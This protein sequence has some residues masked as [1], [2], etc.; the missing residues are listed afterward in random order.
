MDTRPD[1]SEFEILRQLRATPDIFRQLEARGGA[2]LHVQAELRRQFP[3]ALVRAALT[4]R[5][6]RERAAGKF[7]WAEAMWFDRV[8]L[9]QAT[10]EP[11]ARYKAERFEGHVWDYCCGIGSDTA[12]LAD[13]CAVTAVDVDPAA[14]LR[15]KWNA[16]VY[17]VAD[18]VTVLC[19]DVTML[20]DRHGLLHIDPDRRPGR[21]GRV[22]RVEDSIPGLDFL[23][24]MTHEFAGG[25]IKLSP[26]GNFMGKFPDAEIE[27]I[28]LSG[29]CKEATI[30]FGE[31]AGEAAFRATVLPSGDSLAGNPLEAYIPVGELGGYLYDP[32]PAIVRSGLIDVLADQIGLKR[33]DAAEEYLTAD[34]F[35]DSPFVRGFRVLAEL[36]NNDREIRRFFRTHEFGQVEIKCRRIP[37]HVEA[38]RRKLPLKGARPGVIV[39]A[40][41]LG[42]ARAVVCERIG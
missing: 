20:S 40:R 5:D 39:F 19:A 15:T 42:R 22:V 1:E 7:T 10:A 24:Q 16:E 30:W 38:V 36:P 26:A 11:V 2:E 18:H 17:G 29:E 9:E 31:L 23:T 8:G 32:D 6:L 27:L 41:I 3:D 34:V 35:V 25:A 21:G 4:L 37:I 28:S 13:H 14:C 12:A 33:L